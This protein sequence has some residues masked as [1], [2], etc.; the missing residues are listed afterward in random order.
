MTY[1]DPFYGEWE[2]PPAIEKLVHT[3]EMVRLR[4][5]TQSVMPNSLM[6]CGTI[7]SRFHHGLGACFLSTILLKANPALKDYEALLPV[8]ALLHDAGNP[9]FSHLSEYFLKEITGKDGESFLE[10]IL[11]GSETEKVLREL[12]LSVAQVVSFVTGNAKPVSEALNGSIDVDNLD[13]VFRY[14][15]AASVGAPLFMPI[16]IARSFR[17]EN[18]AWLILDECREETE[19]WQAARAMVYGAIYGKPHLNVAMMMY[20]A[21][22]LAFLQDELSKEFF[23]LDDSGA[24]NYLLTQCNPKTAHLVEKALRWEWFEEVVS[25]ESATPANAIKLLASHR[26]GRTKLA[27]L[28]SQTLGIP[29]EKIS[30]YVGKGK[31][32]RRITIPF[33][34]KDGT[35]YLDQC[36]DSPI[37][38]VKVY[39]APDMTGKKN[40]IAEFVQEQ[41]R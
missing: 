9:P 8:A 21:V 27:G 29:D 16:W 1:C 24:V 41:I 33:V 10:E 40:E 23:F 15:M 30:V 17:F 4:N 20:R 25:V 11:D 35:T 6:P 22:E 2:L 39:I 38:R 37:Y 28:I 13:N 19:K 7:P 31:D 34:K 36:D 5:I 26:S 18:G 3:K 14:D 32:K 12:G